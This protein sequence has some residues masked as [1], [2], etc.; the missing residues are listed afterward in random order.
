[1]SL[2]AVLASARSWV[3]TIEDPSGSNH[4]HGIT[5]WLAGTNQGYAWCAAAVSRWMSDG[6]EHDLYKSS[7]GADGQYTKGFASVAELAKAFQDEGRFFT[8]DPKIGDLVIRDGYSH[9][10]LVSAVHSDGTFEV[11]AGNSG[12]HTDSV[13][14]HTYTMEGVLGFA[15]PNYNNDGKYSSS[16]GPTPN[17][18]HGYPGTLLEEGDKGANVRVIQHQLNRSGE[19][20]QEDGQFGSNTEAAVRHFQQGHGLTVDGIVGAKTWAAL[21]GKNE[22]HSSGAGSGSSNDTS[23]KSTGTIVEKGDTGSNV[24]TV[25]ERLNQHGEHL[26]DD[27]IFGSQTEAAVRHF[28]E[29]HGLTADGIV[30]AK[31]WTALDGKDEPVTAG[32]GSGSSKAASSQGTGTSVPEHL[33]EFGSTVWRYINTSMNGAA[34]AADFFSKISAGPVDLGKVVNLSAAATGAQFGVLQ[35]TMDWLHHH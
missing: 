7:V 2:Q 28:Q 3:G 11:I 20:L 31:T 33:Q 35:A 23:P 5:D 9:V 24:H 27:G 13:T 32:L 6:G 25:Q 30:G 19:H 22:P 17:S 29:S 26:Q 10:G 18:N 4:V 1:V 15:R 8:S 21:W 34:P 14:D 16:V 12:S